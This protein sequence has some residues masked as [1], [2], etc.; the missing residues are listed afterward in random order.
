MWAI[1]K[2]ISHFQRDFANANAN[3]NGNVNV[4]GNGNDDNNVNGHV[5]RRRRRPPDIEVAHGLGG[6]GAGARPWLVEPEP[7]EVEVEGDENEGDEN[8]RDERDEIGII[9]QV[10]VDNREIDNREIDNAR[11]E[12]GEGGGVEVGAINQAPLPLAVDV[13]PALF[14]QQQHVHTNAPTATARERELLK[15]GYHSLID[16]MSY[17]RARARARA[18]ALYVAHVGKWLL[19]S[20]KV[21]VLGGLWLVLP[22]L[23]IGYIIEAVLIV[24]FRTSLH[25]TPIYPLTQCWALGLIFLKIWTRSVLVRPQPLV[26]PQQ[27]RAHRNY[28]QAMERVMQVRTSRSMSVSSS[29]SR[30]EID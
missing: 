17:N 26:Q 14:Q 22:P 7:V 18:R 25:E 2:F 10:Q 12:I 11:L 9:D 24:P 5:R 13:E 30:S 20:L 16:E 19:I 23:L 8:E 28:R 29:T 6:L 27:E 15:R 3:V 21:L 1:F 4:N